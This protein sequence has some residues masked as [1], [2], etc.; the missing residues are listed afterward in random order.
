MSDINV[1]FSTPPA[2]NVT[3]QTP[4][5]ISVEFENWQWPAGP[6]WKSAYELYIEDWGTLS[7]EDYIRPPQDYYNRAEIDWQFASL[8]IYYVR[9]W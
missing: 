2:I 7:E 9:Q 4:A 6:P 8:D 1:T 5:P 3:F